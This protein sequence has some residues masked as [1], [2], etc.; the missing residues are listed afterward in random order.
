MTD[1]KKKMAKGAA[2]LVLFRLLERGIGLISTLFLARLLVPADF[3][4][5]AM[6]TSIL[7]ALELLSSFSF[8]LVLIQNQN[9]ERKHY[10]TAWT[11][12]LTFGIVNALGMCAF[13]S[14]AATFFSEPRVEGLMYALALSPL[15]AGFDNIG[16]VAFQKNLELH[17]EFWLGLTKKLVGFVVTISMAYILQN[18]WALVF[19]IIAS[20]LISLIL[21]YKLH[22]YRPKFSFAAAGELFNF[23]KWLLLNN[24]L[25]FMNN[26][27]TDFI[28]GRF[29]GA[30]ALGLYSVSYELANLPTS[31]LVYPISRAVFPGYARLA[32]DREQLRQAFL[33]V[34]G[35]VAL[36][37]IPAGAGIGLVAVPLVQVLLGAK[38]IDAVPLIQ[39]LAVFGIIR[40]MHGPNGSIYLALGK[41][42][43]VAALQCVQLTI[44]IGLMIFL[45]PKYGSIGAA[46]AIL[47]GAFVAMIAN[48]IMV[49]RELSLPIVEL[50][51]VVWRPLVAATAMAITL[52]ALAAHLWPNE[53]GVFPNAM[54]LATMIVVGATSYGMSIILCWKLAGKPH[55]TEADLLTLVSSRLK[56]FFLNP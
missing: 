30:K 16:V 41:P 29:S 17:K 50:M 35:L 13:A 52:V 40:S 23:S 49:L 45:V 14:I 36:L 51:A 28:I 4:L 34:I 6:A 10:D 38:W 15:I 1:L 9:A 54:R 24:F 55:G 19:G 21:S 56:R 7:A 12:G 33:Q 26:R 2:W 22:P 53:V 39:V 32:A 47:I 48:Y 42:R 37:T 43:I 25:I 20:R 3:G 27:G 5:V 46:W 18:Y 44:A 11:F 8:D 31:E